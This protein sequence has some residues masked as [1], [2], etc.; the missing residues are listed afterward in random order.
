[1]FLRAVL[2]FLV[3]PGVAAFLLPAVMGRLDPWRLGP[4]LLAAPVFV[5]GVAGL[6]WCVR[7]FYFIGKGTL[8]PWRPPTRLVVAGLYRWVRNP[9]YLAV[10]MLSAGWALVYGSPIVAAY[11]LVLAAVFHLR[12]VW[13]EE[14]RLRRQFGA[15]YGDYCEQV[16]R[17][18]CR[19]WPRT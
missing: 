8:A 13:Y 2:A 14:P 18:L 5:A 9:M 1:M 6:A 4:S 15:T 17:W 16:P 12:V 10:L 3:L 11:S 19:G 7:D